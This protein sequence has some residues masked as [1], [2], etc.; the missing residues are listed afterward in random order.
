MRI[1]RAQHENA[2]ALNYHIIRLCVCASVC[3]TCRTDKSNTGSFYR[4]AFKI[5]TKILQ[6][7]RKRLLTEFIS[8]CLPVCMSPSLLQ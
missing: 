5:C 3:S 8:L 4:T 7:N 1:F 6:H 2:K